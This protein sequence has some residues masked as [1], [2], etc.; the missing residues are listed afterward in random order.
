VDEVSWPV[1]NPE[2]QERSQLAVCVCV[3]VC[4]VEVKSAAFTLS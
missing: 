4:E 1:V 2:T 3:C